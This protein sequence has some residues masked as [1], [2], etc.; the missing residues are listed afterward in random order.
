MT[1]L[2]S[3]QNYAS[4]YAIYP[5]S[6]KGNVTEAMYL[7]LGLVGEAGEVAEKIK[8]MYRDE[9]ITL[10]VKEL[11]KELGDVLWYLSQLAKWSGWNLHDVADLNL[12]KLYDRKFRNMLKG[13]GDNR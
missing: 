2:N 9:H 6:G 4:E 11:A 13:S 8:K 12:A 1:D 7:A 5:D 10:D 3:Y